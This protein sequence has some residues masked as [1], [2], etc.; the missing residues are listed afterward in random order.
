MS[1][2]SLTSNPASSLEMRIRA[3]RLQ[4]SDKASRMKVL[5]RIPDE[6][7]WPIGESQ[8]VTGSI[9]GRLP[10]DQS[11]EKLKARYEFVQKDEIF[12]FLRHYPFLIVDL[13]KIYEIKSRYFGDSPM[14]L[15]YL[16]ETGSLES[17]TL[18]AHIKINIPREEAN[19]TFSRFDNEW[20]NGISKE[21]KTLIMVDMV[22]NV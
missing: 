4:R 5:W 11:I 20:W 12:R 19:E 1:A 22:V 2:N 21:A 18:S 8:V 14:D 13:S 16:S 6:S 17:A 3:E 15:Y 10:F 9:P 7:L